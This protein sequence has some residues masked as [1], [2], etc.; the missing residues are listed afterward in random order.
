MNNKARNKNVVLKK[1]NGKKKR[2]TLTPVEVSPIADPA[3]KD[4]ITLSVRFTPEQRERIA[5]AAFFRGWT[6]TN[7]LRV[8][9]ME[10]AAY[11]LNTALPTKMN[12]RKMAETVANSLMSEGKQLTIKQ[13]KELKY[14][15][16]VGGGE[17]LNLIVDYC[18]DVVSRTQTDLPEPIDPVID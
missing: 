17:F 7:L 12:L 18:L 8:A 3:F 9:A 13:L 11:V 16:H 10:K 2:E 4:A 5:R 14:G 1:P 15:A 6:P